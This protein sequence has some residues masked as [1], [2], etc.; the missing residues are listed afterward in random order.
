MLLHEFDPNPQA[1][2]N[3]SHAA[4]PVPGMPRVMVSCFASVTFD[5]M[6]RSLKAEPMAE[7]KTA[8]MVYPIYRA[9][10]GGVPVALQMA[11]VGAPV[12]A[13]NLE[14]CYA[15]GVETVVLFGNCGVL[16][17][18]IGDCSIILP[19]AAL[20]DEGTSYHYA[21]PSEEIEVNP[22]YRDVFL[23]LLEELGVPHTR[24]KTWTTD[25]FYRE[26]REKVARRRAQGCVCVEMEAAAVAAMAQFRKKE[27]FIFFYAGD[28]LDGD[29]WD[30]RS[31]S[32]QTMID[33]KDR[34]ALLALE[35]AKRITLHKTK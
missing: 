8:N 10:Y 20:R 25:A 4:A 9:V 27:A 24:G 6:V 35:M 16:D 1:V 29:S 28:S 18:T 32:G 14:E 23:G 7:T 5:R 11:A 33:E 12:C 17:G 30:A 26:T 34:V 21:P 19:T 2:I 31:L 22:R 13:G 3:P 15:M